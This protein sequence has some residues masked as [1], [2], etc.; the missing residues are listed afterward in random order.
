MKKKNSSRFQRLLVPIILT[1]GILSL[2]LTG[3]KNNEDKKH[4]EDVVKNAEAYYENKYG[5]KAAISDYYTVGNHGT[6]GWDMIF[7]DDYV[8]EMSD[9]TKVY[10]D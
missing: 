3:C 10:W 7:A 4:H 9:G 6:F 8:F 1:V 2:F 5:E